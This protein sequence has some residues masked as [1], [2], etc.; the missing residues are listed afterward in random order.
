MP[1][2]WRQAETVRSAPLPLSLGPCSAATLMRAIAAPDQPLGRRRDTMTTL[3]FT[4]GTLV[5][6]DQLLPDGVVAVDGTRIRAVRSGN[7]WGA[8]AGM[9]VVDLHGGYLVPGFV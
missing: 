5:L 6:A 1:S 4:G 3:L 8:E 7:G 2:G 9:E